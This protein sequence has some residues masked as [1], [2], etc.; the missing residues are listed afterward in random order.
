MDMSFV[1]SNGTLYRV[2]SQSWLFHPLVRRK[3]RGFSHDIIRLRGYRMGQGTDMM[4]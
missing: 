2:V 1:M 3:F 4:I